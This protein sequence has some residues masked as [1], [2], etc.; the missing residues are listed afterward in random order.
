[1]P[2]FVFAFSRSQTTPLIFTFLSLTF[3]WSFKG[4]HKPQEEQRARTFSSED[5]ALMFVFFFHEDQPQAL[6]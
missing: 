2:F 1:M 4:A 5:H 6:G 3:L